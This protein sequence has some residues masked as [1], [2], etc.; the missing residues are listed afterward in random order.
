MVHRVLQETQDLKDQQV[1]KVLKEPKVLQV[2]NLVPKGTRE[3]KER[4]VLKVPP[5]EDLQGFKVLRVLRV[6]KVTQD[7]QDHQVSPTKD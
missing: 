4:Q 6:R 7:S 3:L 1:S 2:Q 5:V